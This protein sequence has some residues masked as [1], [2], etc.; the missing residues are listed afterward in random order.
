MSGEI[1]YIFS[2][3]NNKETFIY[4]VTQLS[5]EI[6]SILEDSYSAVWVTGEVS[7]F[8]LLNSGHM[9]FNIIDA[10]AQVKAVMF[11]SVNIDLSFTPKDGMKVLVYGKVSSYIKHGGYQIVVNHM[12]RYGKG[13]LYE[14]YERLKK[15]LEAEG[16]FDKSLKKPI[17]NIVNRIGIVTSR[18]G[19]ALFDILKVID[20]LGA[21][22]EV[23]IYPVKVQGKEAEKEIPEAIKYLNCHYRNLDVLLIGRGGGSVEDLW[24]FNTETVARAIFDSEIPVVSCVGHE[25]DFTIADFVADM[26]APTPSAAAEIVL[27][28]RNDV[29]N[30][31]EILRKSLSDATSFILD[32][33]IGKFYRLMSSKA[34]TE[35]HLMYENKISY[36][37]ELNN[38]LL[39]NVDRV[40]ESKS[41][42]LKYIC[43]KLD[44]L[45]P[46]FILKR[47]FSVCYDSNNEVIKDSKSVN[48][49]DNIRIKFASGGLNAEV[50]SYE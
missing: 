44:I 13:E 47:G 32:G 20:S 33:Y 37:N 18:N 39:K 35:P 38:R 9:Y 19:A 10:N 30:R 7:S 27:R 28:N 25:V 4:T 45:Y 43:H 31:I 14:D 5:N 49:G 11:K 3:S 15:K 6:K 36:L 41:V 21:N 29:K 17:P 48:I 2:G 22:V 26:R 12:E 23:L 40:I 46:L 1:E 8:K 16:I 24:A 50:K 42:K 34:L